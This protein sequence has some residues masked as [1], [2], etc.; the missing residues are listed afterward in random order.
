MLLLVGG[1]IEKPI[2]KSIVYSLRGTKM[3]CGIVN[4]NAIL[5]D[6]V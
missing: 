2:I 4:K 3:Q 5:R 1:G 6:T